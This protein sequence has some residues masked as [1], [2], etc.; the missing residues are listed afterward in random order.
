MALQQVA[1]PWERVDPE[2][3]KA[4]KK[5]TTSNGEKTSTSK[6][7]VRPFSRPA[8]VPCEQDRT[9]N[10]RAESLQSPV[11]A[12]KERSLTYRANRSAERATTNARLE[13]DKAT[14]KTNEKS[15]R[16]ISSYRVQV[17]AR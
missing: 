9:A 7:R 13:L 15:L 2:Y 16:N 1:L 5:G 10:V 8:I 3:P 6:Q 4:P 12:A 11:P 17:P 14:E